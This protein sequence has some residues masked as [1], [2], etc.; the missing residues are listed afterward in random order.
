[1]MDLLRSAAGH[2][3]VIAVAILGVVLGGVVYVLEMRKSR[4][5]PRLN[6]EGS[7]RGGALR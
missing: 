2:T 4:L 6:S 3:M 7:G 1:M 5:R